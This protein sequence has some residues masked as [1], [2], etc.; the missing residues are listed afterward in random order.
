MSEKNESGCGSCL[1]TLGSLA[2]VVILGFMFTPH[3]GMFVRVGSSVF[4][5]GRPTFDG[6]P[7]G[8]TVEAETVEANKKVVVEAVKT[9]HGRL[10][11]GKCDEIYDQS[12]SSALK[13]YQSKAS[14][15]LLCD[16]WKQ[17]GGLKSTEIA[18]WWGKPT[19]NQDRLMLIRYMTVTQNTPILETFVWL[20]NK[21][22]KAELVS[23]QA[24]PD[25]AVAKSPSPSPTSE[26]NKSNR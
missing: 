8:T 9:L 14:F 12:T 10:D 16:Q 19:E 15:S 21:E 26:E 11:Q 2:V 17:T 24:Q 25:S 7:M 3:G 5:F 1:G 23:Y 18:D 22:S 13:N 4:T 6:K 20:I